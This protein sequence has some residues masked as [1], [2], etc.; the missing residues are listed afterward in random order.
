M[1]GVPLVSEEGPPIGSSPSLC[2]ARALAPMLKGI[3]L[4]GEQNEELVDMDEDEDGEGE[5]DGANDND[6]VQDGGGSGQAGG[7]GHCRECRQPLDL[8]PC[9][10]LAERVALHLDGCG[11]SGHQGAMRVFHDPLTT[12]TVSWWTCCRT[13]SRHVSRALM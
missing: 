12:E 13:A 2:L 9:L 3:A 6:A 8:L 5:G 1:D 10:D 11:S 7:W 4:T